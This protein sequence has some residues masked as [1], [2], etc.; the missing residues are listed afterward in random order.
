MSQ[1]GLAICMYKAV[2][3]SEPSKILLTDLAGC[4]FD[5]YASL[6]KS[7]QSLIHVSYARC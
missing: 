5:Q 4:A 2:L 7:T 3:L 6:L 1:D